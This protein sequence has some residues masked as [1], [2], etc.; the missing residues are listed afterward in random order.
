[1]ASPDPIRLAETAANIH[2][3]DPSSFAHQYFPWFADMTPDDKEALIEL[4]KTF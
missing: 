2:A 1:M 3:I 4:L